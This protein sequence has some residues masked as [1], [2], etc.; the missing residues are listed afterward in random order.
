[1]KKRREQEKTRRSVRGKDGLYEK[2]RVRERERA[3]ER[4]REEYR[5]DGKRLY[6]TCLEAFSLRLR[7]QDEKVRTSLG[8][9]STWFADKDSGGYGEEK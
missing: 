7:E 4:E 8:P 2:G 1:M 6:Y 3:R 5:G 9:S